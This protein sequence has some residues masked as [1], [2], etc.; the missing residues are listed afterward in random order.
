MLWGILYEKALGI[1]SCVWEFLYLTPHPKIKLRR[2]TAIT[3]ELPGY[4]L[5]SYRM[6]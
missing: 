6:I 2:I 3:R 4:S 1:H 5:F